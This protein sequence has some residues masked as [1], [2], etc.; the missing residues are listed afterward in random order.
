MSDE[1]QYLGTATVPYGDWV[2][3]ASADTDMVKGRNI[4]DVTGLDDDTWQIVGLDIM[5]CCEFPADVFVYAASKADWQAHRVEQKESLAVTSFLCHD[6]TM[7][8]IVAGMKQF[9]VQLR[10]RA[11]G[12]HPMHIVQNADIQNRISTQRGYA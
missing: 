11:I 3:T 9:R 1:R 10:I 8:D 12:D 4:Y 7:D 5:D 2:G 6:L